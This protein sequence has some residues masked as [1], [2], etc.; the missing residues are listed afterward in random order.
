MKNGGRNSS[1]LEAREG[2][3]GSRMR[4]NGNVTMDNK[5]RLPRVVNEKNGV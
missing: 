5:P 1:M 3:R 2:L 4:D